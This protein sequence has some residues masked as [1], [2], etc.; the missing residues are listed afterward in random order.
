MEAGL[1]SE[2]RTI[3]LLTE[4][5]HIPT[6][7]TVDQ[8]RGIYNSICGSLDYEN[9]TR[10]ADGARIERCQGETPDTSTV[11]FRQD[12]VIM[13]EDNTTLTLEQY[14]QKLEVVAR[15]AMEALNL[16][17]FLVQQTT[18]RAIASP[19]AFK[20]G[21]EFIGKSLFRITPDDLRPLGRPTS[22]FGF[23]LFFPATKE[24]PYQF[25]VRVESYVKDNRSIYIENV[26]MFKT[27]IQHANIDVLGKNV[28]ATADF[29]ATNLCRFLSRF[30]RQD[31]SL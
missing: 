18:V 13:V 8:L 21:G 11:T 27:P 1:L 9:F 4:L 3:S 19:N 2:P 31:T 28:Q 29:L 23:R 16:P 10:T 15:T 7:S 12:R 30:D 5:I 26:G 14:T 24:Q 25:N 17:F 22:I 6:K 20:T